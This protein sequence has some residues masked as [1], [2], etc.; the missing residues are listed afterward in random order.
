MLK[1]IILLSLLLP[2]CGDESKEESKTIGG[3]SETIAKEKPIKCT[4]Y[5]KVYSEDG[6]YTTQQFSNYEIANLYLKEE[7]KHHKSGITM[8]ILTTSECK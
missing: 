2:S 8:F 1:K 4:T 6:L 7:M 5:Y 3:E